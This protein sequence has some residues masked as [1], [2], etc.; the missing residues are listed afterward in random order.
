M[1]L[2]FSVVAIL[3]SDLTILSD[4]GKK[5]K[6]P[7]KNQVENFIKNGVKDYQR[8]APS[9]SV[10]YVS[11]K[12][13]DGFTRLELIGAE[14]KRAFASV[15][16]Q[17]IRPFGEGFLLIESNKPAYFKQKSTA[18]KAYEKQV[19]ARLKTDERVVYADSTVEETQHLIYEPR[20]LLLHYDGTKLT[21]KQWLTE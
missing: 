16:Y 1:T 20:R 5:E 17:Q 10:I 18:L 4:I 12:I 2:I 11:V 14:T 7:T 13:G 21:I 6:E 9:T 15:R 19:I 8:A 3:L